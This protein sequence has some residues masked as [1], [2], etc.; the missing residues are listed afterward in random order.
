MAIKL[1]QIVR[2][3]ISGFEGIVIARTEWL[4]GCTGIGVR[5]KTLKEDGTIRDTQWFDEPTLDATAQDP[6]GVVSDGG[7]SNRAGK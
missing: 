1:G 6:G 3:R 7:P 5:S 4:Y 2:D